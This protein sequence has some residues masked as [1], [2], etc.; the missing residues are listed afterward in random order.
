MDSPP[1]LRSENPLPRPH[2]TYV[3]SL[4]NLAGVLSGAKHPIRG[5]ITSR[6]DAHRITHNYYSGTNNKSFR[7]AEAL[8]L[9]NRFNVSSV[10]D[11]RGRLVRRRDHHDQDHRVLDL[12]RHR[13][14]DVH[15]VPG[16]RRDLRP[17]HGRLMVRLRFP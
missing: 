3:S 13:R 2:G 8:I 14:P 16:R 12:Y 9:S 17:G 4:E 5:K 1:S 7:K 15:L 11:H 10:W 6:V